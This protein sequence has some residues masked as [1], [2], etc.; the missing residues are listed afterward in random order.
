MGWDE[1]VSGGDENSESDGEPC[2]MIDGRFDVCVPPTSGDTVGGAG[3]GGIGTGVLGGANVTGPPTSPVLCE[4]VLRRKL[5]RKE[6][7]APGIHFWRKF[8]VTLSPP[9]A[10]SSTTPNAANR[11]DR[12]NT[13]SSHPT[14]LPHLFTP[15]P[16]DFH[17]VLPPR[18]FVG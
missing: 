9:P 10:L 13:F 1:K 15:P 3:T 7:K 16:L 6:S 5:V 18:D 12:D 11:L 17:I 14:P 4:G 2:R 8:W